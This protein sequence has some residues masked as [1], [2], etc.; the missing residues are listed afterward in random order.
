LGVRANVI[1][2]TLGATVYMSVHEFMLFGTVLVNNWNIKIG[3]HDKGTA[4]SCKNVVIV[5]VKAQQSHHGGI[6]G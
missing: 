5:Y 4:S 1:G 2:P 3:T 6:V